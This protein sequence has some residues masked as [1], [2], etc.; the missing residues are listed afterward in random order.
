[1]RILA[2]NLDFKITPTFCNF[3]PML[4][5]LPVTI[6]EGLAR[7]RRLQKLHSSK[8]KAIQM[9][10]ILKQH[11][12]M[13]KDQLAARTGASDKSIHTWRSCYIT[14]GIKGLLPEKRGGKK[15]G[16][17]TVSIKE[18]LERKLINPNEPFK[19]FI[20]I[21]RWLLTEFG[22]EMKYHAV[23]KYIKRKFGPRLIINCKN[24][25]KNPLDKEAVLQNLVE[26]S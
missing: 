2:L 21:Q 14:N 13:S 11:G 15:P 26:K 22:I 4:Q 8:Y 25:Q 9:L 6:K 24:N 17:I 5:P 12:A 1:M 19:S 16:K 7:L 18:Q 10:I 20:E 23:N 3:V